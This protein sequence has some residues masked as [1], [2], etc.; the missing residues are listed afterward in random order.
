MSCLFRAIIGEDWM[1][2]YPAKVKAVVELSQPGSKEDVH[3]L[4]GMVASFKDF[5]PDMST[6]MFPMR[7]LLK[8]DV[9]S[10]WLPKHEQALNKI[11][12]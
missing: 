10:Q 11:K 3:R 6:T 8:N 4:M 1:R 7:Q 9:D 12:K 2:P 5:I